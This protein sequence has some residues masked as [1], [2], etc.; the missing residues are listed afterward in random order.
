MEERLFPIERKLAKDSEK[1]IMYWEAVSQCIEDG[2]A[3][4]IDEKDD[5]AD[6]IRYIPH[7]GVFREERA[8]K[9]YRVVFHSSERTPDGTWNLSTSV[10]LTVQN[11]SQMSDLF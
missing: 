1:A 7:H 10:F 8:T 2:Y 5:K 6:K 9:M 11:F 4:P 3:R